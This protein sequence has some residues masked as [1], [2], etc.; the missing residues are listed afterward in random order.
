[1]KFKNIFKSLNEATYYEPKYVNVELF[2]NGT[3]KGGLAPLANTT[4]TIIEKPKKGTKVI[5]IIGSAVKPGVDNPVYAL[6]Q[7]LSLIHI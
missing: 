2:I 6:A 7:D 1:M 5:E 3:A 4:V